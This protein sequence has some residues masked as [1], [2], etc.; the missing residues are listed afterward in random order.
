MN[1]R[2]EPTIDPDD[3]EI[4]L[5]REVRHRISERF[6]HDPYRLVAHYIDRQ[7]QREHPSAPAAEPDAPGDAQGP[8]PP[9]SA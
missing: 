9:G 2:P 3:E 4:A 5:I 1:P 8:R 7:H 6:G